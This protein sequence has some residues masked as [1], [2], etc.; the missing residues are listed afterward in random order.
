VSAVRPLLRTAGEG[1]GP[2]YDRRKTIPKCR[3]D[4]RHSPN[5]HV[6]VSAIVHIS[7]MS[8][9][10]FEMTAWTARP[11]VVISIMPSRPVD[12]QRAALDCGS[13]EPQTSFRNTLNI[14]P[15][16]KQ[17]WQTVLALVCLVASYPILP[18]LAWQQRH[19]VP[20]LAIIVI[21]LWV[22]IVP[23][24]VIGFNSTVWAGVSRIITSPF[25]Q[26]QDFGVEI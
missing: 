16:V 23:V 15:V 9:C 4:N 21:A 20:T 5:P 8:Q 1:G 11:R 14:G 18:L 6:P 17:E 22:F 12:G 25:S 3:S 19:E 13:F 7:P 10:H 26:S 24:F 2:R